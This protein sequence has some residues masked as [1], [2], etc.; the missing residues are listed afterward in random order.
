[1]NNHLSSLQWRH[2]ERDGV[3]NHQPHDCLLNRL[4]RHRWK[5]TSKL[6]VSGLCGGNSPVTGEFPAQRASNAENASIWWRHYVHWPLLCCIPYSRLYHEVVIEISSVSRVFNCG[7]R[8]VTGCNFVEC[9]LKK[10]WKSG[11]WN[12]CRFLLNINMGLMCFVLLLSTL[13]P[14]DPFVLT[15]I[16][17]NPT[18]DK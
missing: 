14:W 4:F 6:R 17:F 5:K 18:M 16:Y 7:V 9:W 3:P 2:N 8:L 13:G 12:S 1:M 15:W 11:I 10:Q